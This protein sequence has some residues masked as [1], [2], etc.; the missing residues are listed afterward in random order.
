MHQHLK[1]RI[2]VEFVNHRGHVAPHIQ[3]ACIDGLVLVRQMR[4]AEVV[5]D[6]RGVVFEGKKDGGV[7]AEFLLI[8]GGDGRLD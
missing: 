6:P 3:Q 4:D 2:R 5:P 8:C 1:F 7:R